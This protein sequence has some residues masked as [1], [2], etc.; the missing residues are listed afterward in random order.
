M[1]PHHCGRPAAVGFH[2]VTSPFW[3]SKMKRAGPLAG[4]DPTTK[5]SVSLNT[6]P[7]GAPLV[8]VTSS[9][10]LANGVATPSPR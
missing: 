3:L 2:P 7:V 10:T 9:G 5:L 6:C 8:T 1:R 4:G